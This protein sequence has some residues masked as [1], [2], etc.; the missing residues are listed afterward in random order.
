MGL[1]DRASHDLPLDEP[2]RAA[3]NY[4]RLSA[5]DVRAAF[6]KW[7]RPDALVQVIEGPAPKGN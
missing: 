5:A 7:F 4:L 3:R 2:L 6:A 1:L